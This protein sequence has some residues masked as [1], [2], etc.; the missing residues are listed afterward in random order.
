VTITLQ[1]GLLAVIVVL[2]LVLHYVVYTRRQELVR[3]VHQLESLN[4]ALGLR[5]LRLVAIV[6]D[7]QPLDGQHDLDELVESIHTLFRRYQA[8][9]LI[10]EAAGDVTVTGD[11]VGGSKAEGRRQKAEGGRRDGN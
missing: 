5:L 3:R 1:D 6:R 10:I 4:A 11:V 2:L 8:G 7:G 9:A